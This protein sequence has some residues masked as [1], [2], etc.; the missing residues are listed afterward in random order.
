MDTIDFRAATPADFDFFVELHKQTLGPYVS[1][2]WGWDDGYQRRY[3]QRTIAFEATQV[4]VVN[5]TD[6][7]RLK[8]EDHGRDV[9]IALIEIAPA[10]Q[11]RGIG[12][13]IVRGIL[14]DAFSHGKDV[15]LSV[16]GV[17]SG[18]LRL[19][20]R[21]GFSEVGRDGTAPAVRIQMRAPRPQPR[22]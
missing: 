17:N 8:V 4:I 7:G 1:Q 10:Q 15:R 16:L 22:S 3:L 12:G 19:Y 9:Y 2:V 6:A 11:G 21:L 5:G 20:C 13:R 14:D 18:A